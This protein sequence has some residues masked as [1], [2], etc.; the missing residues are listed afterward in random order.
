[1][2]GPIPFTL[3]QKLNLNIRFPRVAPQIIV[4]NHPVKVK[5]RCRAYVGLQGYYLR[6]VV[7][8][9]FGH[10]CRDIG[11]LGQ[12][13][14]LVHVYDHVKLRLVVQRHDLDGNISGIKQ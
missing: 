10:P 7:A 8:D 5:R 9:K 1:M 11:S 2:T 12:G 6:N 13:G 14:T 4:A 3:M